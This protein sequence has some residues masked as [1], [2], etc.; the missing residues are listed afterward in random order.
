MD[1]ILKAFM[2]SASYLL[3]NKSDMSLV[4]SSDGGGGGGG[5]GGGV[6]A[7]SGN[8]SLYK[9]SRPPSPTPT[10]CLQNDHGVIS[11]GHPNGVH[12]SNGHVPN[13]H[14]CNGHVPQAHPKGH[15]INGQV[16]NG[17]VSKG[18]PSN[19]FTTLKHTPHSSNDPHNRNGYTHSPNSHKTNTYS[20]T[21]LIP[22]TSCSQNGA[23][24]SKTMKNGYIPSTAN[25]C[26]H[27]VANGCVGANPHSASTGSHRWVR[28]LGQAERF[29][30][31]AH[32]F[33]C[34]TTVY[35][36]WLDARQPVSFH[37]I[38]YAAT[39]VQRK[40]PHLRMVLGIKDD[41]L[42]WR[43]LTNEIVDVEEMETDDV[44][45]TFES[46]LRRRY[47]MM[48]GPLWFVRLVKVKEEDDIRD[49]NHNLK[50]RYV[51]IFGFHHNVSDGTT[52]MKFCNIFLSVL[53][54]LMQGK[55]VDMKEEGTFAP[56]IHDEIAR[57]IA[58]KW[59]LLNVFL[60]RLFRG[61][62]CYGSYVSN[63][64]RIFPLPAHK[65]ASTNVLHHELDELT[66]QRL[67]KRCKMENVTLNSAF[68]A[69]AN[70]SLFR[71]A[72]DQGSKLSSTSF[73]S[74]H[75]INMRRYWP[76]EKQPNTYGCHISMLDIEVPTTVEDFDNFWEYARRV[77]GNFLHVI[78]KS[79]RAL[80]LMPISQKLRLIIVFNS[81]LASL[82]LPSTNDNH[83]CTTNMGDLSNTF[84]GTGEEVEVSK[85]LRS[86]SCHLMP[87]LCQHTLQ[88]F[89]GKFCYSL[90]YYTQK[91][92]PETAVTYAK[93]I[94]DMLTHV[95]HTPN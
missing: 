81:W 25:G 92:E 42:W 87:T 50:Y 76:K 80:K 28:P 29:M 17:C 26:A 59:W 32:D 10:K 88:T 83:Y 43:E 46:L 57:K 39:L 82:G 73:D 74:V 51:V 52:N 56:P 23:V 48:E 69:A 94:L 13:G 68:T 95:I 30:T 91:F 15:T 64:T 67:L 93:T 5:G 71:M 34:M 77:H 20:S 7:P 9:R 16:P 70:L 3:S 18:Y 60:R 79:Q 63:I 21:E 54:R 75:A 85:V 33:G 62:I 6:D 31:D 90:D 24:P 11:N 61:I 55:E 38:K 1:T 22:E 35:A 45:Q 65:E 4:A 89:R 2:S 19:G 49:S 58:S 66:T 44:I 86:V 8:A 41:D 84:P 53:N 14:V 78:T 37:V 40:M 72:L 27:S 36:L 47:R 12:L